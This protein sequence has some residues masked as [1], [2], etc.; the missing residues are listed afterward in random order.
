MRTML[1]GSLMFV[2]SATLIGCAPDAPT[3]TAAPDAPL[4]SAVSG[5]QE[6]NI[7]VP[8]DLAVFVPC[9][10]DG[11]GEFVMLSG[12]LH[13]KNDILFD[14]RGGVH[15][16]SHAQPMGVSG[17]GAVSGDR[18]QGTGVTRSSLNLTAG[19]TQ[20]MINNFRIIGQGSGNNAMVHVNTHITVN[21]NG[22]LTASVDNASS[23]CG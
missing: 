13:L 6:Q 22:E 19:V 1:R 20:T 18:Y 5:G 3:P 8:L 11:A 14:G 12:M 10:V 17:T 4:F 2:V 21:A 16:R 15:V 23:T 7:I 9:A